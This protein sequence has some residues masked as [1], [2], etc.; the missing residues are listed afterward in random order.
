MEFISSNITINDFL[1]KKEIT[2]KEF[3]D[4]LASISEYDTELHKKYM[5]HINQKQ[6][7]RYA[8]LV[9]KTDLILSLMKNGIVNEETNVKKE[10]DILDYYINTNLTPEQFLEI[11][12][13][14]YKR[15]D[16]VLIRTFFAKNKIKNSEEKIIREAK[17]IINSVEITDEQKDIV[18]NYLK[19][20]KAPINTKIFRLALR[21]Y[22]NNELILEEINRKTR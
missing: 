14:Q 17:F 7:E 12:K 1:N 4:A 20:I 3:S 22:L 13:K 15:N 9:S 5:D 2:K 18:I 19:Q 6:S 16:L 10:F 11:S 8:V 21:R